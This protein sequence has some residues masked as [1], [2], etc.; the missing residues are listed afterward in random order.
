MAKSHIAQEVDMGKLRLIDLCDALA[1]VALEQNT[2]AHRIV[3]SLCFLRRELSAPHP[4]RSPQW[5]YDVYAAYSQQMTKSKLWVSHGVTKQGAELFPPFARLN[6]SVGEVYLYN[7]ETLEPVRREIPNR[8]E[9][10]Q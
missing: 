7:N 5:G 3:T 4:E 8:M 2:D 10:R 1:T 6:G 9:L